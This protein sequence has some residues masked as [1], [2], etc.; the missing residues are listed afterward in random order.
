MTRTT[1]D[2]DTST[3]ARLR[4]FKTVKSESY[5]DELNRI[6]DKLDEIGFFNPK[7]HKVGDGK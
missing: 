5:D 3:R 4:Q 1:L 6:M 2:L 7:I